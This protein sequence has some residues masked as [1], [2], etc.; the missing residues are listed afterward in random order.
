MFRTFV[1]IDARLIRCR[2]AV[3]DVCGQW[4]MGAM[5]VRS[6]LTQNRYSFRE[7]PESSNFIQHRFAKTVTLNFNNK[8]LTRYSRTC[9]TYNREQKKNKMYT[10]LQVFLS[11]PNFGRI[12]QYFR[13]DTVLMNEYLLLFWYKSK[14]PIG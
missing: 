1:Y 13:S 7:T 10:S 3:N 12:L 14:V 2:F 9:F 4:S 6:G 8:T 5:T 11:L